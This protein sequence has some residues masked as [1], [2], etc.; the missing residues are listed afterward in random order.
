[1]D[2]LAVEF[3]MQNVFDTVAEMSHDANGFIRVAAP[4]SSFA[5]FRMR[6]GG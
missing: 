1:M 3:G 6:F 4:R 2:W 5:G